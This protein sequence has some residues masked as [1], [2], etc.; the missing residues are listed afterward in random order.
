MRLLTFC[1]FV[2]SSAVLAVTTAARAGEAGECAAY[3]A[4]SL[5]GLATFVWVAGFHTYVVHASVNPSH[6][7]K[8]TFVKRQNTLQVDGR[9][10][11]TAN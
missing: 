4:A 3:L 11:L 8:R 5:A 2:A 1:G 10:I 9:V 6:R 7:L